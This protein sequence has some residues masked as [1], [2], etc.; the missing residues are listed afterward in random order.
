MKR[1]KLFFIITLMLF[2]K[3][4]V[5]SQCISIDLSIKWETGFDIFNEDSVVCIPKLHITYRNNSKINYYFL[6]VSDSKTGLPLIPYGGLLQYPIEEYL[7]PDYLKRAK[8][9]SNYENQNYHVII[10]GTLLYKQGWIIEN[11]T[12]NC[13]NE[14]EIDMIND[15]LADIYEYIYRKH[16][17]EYS[18]LVKEVKTHFS[19]IDITPNEISNKMKGHFAFLKPGEFI[20][21]T[22]NLIGF[23][24]VGGNFDFRIQ[25]DTLCG[26][27]YTEPTWDKKQKKWIE[28]KTDLPDKVGEYSLYKGV[29]NSNQLGIKFKGQTKSDT[30]I[31]NP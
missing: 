21:E 10:G 8:L 22:Y 23:K 13:Q 24:M 31:I 15:D 25:K 7:H 9:H 4:S 29:F 19:T 26:F 18:D 1:K 17:S 2:Q 30:L 14:H 27:V 5:L 11:D 12:I 28:I 3:Q 20:T 6:K 16:Y